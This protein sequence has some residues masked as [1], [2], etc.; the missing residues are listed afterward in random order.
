M[1]HEEARQKNIEGYKEKAGEYYMLALR[2]M[3]KTVESMK[4]IH[5]AVM[6]EPT[7]YEIRWDGG[8]NYKL[9]KRN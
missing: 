2:Y 9:T 8:D 4:S 5:E 6:H 7:K 3:E 1:K